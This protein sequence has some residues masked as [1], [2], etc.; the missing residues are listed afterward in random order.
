LEEEQ[1]DKQDQK[2]YLMPAEKRK[3]AFIK[4]DVSFGTFPLLSASSSYV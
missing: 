1:A 3:V 4:R 2:V